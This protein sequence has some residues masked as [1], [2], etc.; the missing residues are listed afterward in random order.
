MRMRVHPAQPFGFEPCRPQCVEKPQRA[1][2]WIDETRTPTRPA[3]FRSRLGEACNCTEPRLGAQRI[4]RLSPFFGGV[5][6]WIAHDQTTAFVHSNQLGDVASNHLA[7]HAVAKQVAGAASRLLPI[8]LDEQAAFRGSECQQ[9]DANHPAACTEVS[10]DL[11]RAC[12]VCKLHEVHGVG[13]EAVAVLRLQ[14]RELKVRT[15][16]KLGRALGSVATRV[17]RRASSRGHAHARTHY[18]RAR[19]LRRVQGM[20]SE[21]SAASSQPRREPDPLQRRNTELVREFATALSFDVV[22]FASAQAPLEEEYA[23]YEAFLDSGFEGSMDWLREGREVRRR[24]DTSDM[25]AGAQSVVCLARNYHRDDDAKDTGLAPHIARYA[26]GR[27]YHNVVRRK[28]RQLAAFIRKLGAEA[29]PLIDD[30]PILEK[31]WAARAGL[32][33]VGKNGLLIVPGQGSYVLL[34]EVLTTLSLEPGSAIAQRCGSCTRCLDACPTD[35]FA[36]PF[37]LDPRRCISYWTIE[38]EGVVPPSIEERTGAWVFG[39][40]VCQ[41]VC[42]FN[43]GKHVGAST[44]TFRPHERWEQRSIA[45]LLDGAGDL[46][47]TPLARAGAEGLARNAAIALGNTGYVDGSAEHAALLRAAEHGPTPDVREHAA[48]ALLRGK[49]S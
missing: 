48:R 10:H 44:E 27:D 3:E 41:E 12:G 11:D 43:A 42:P 14:Q 38:N 30:A 29:R 13:I 36:A 1:A 33:F 5:I 49:R 40:D 21:D 6:G 19:P 37:V 28:L 18:T 47:G 17:E 4:A 26:R 22:G 20:R 46:S 32:G 34:G 23:R 39:C 2:G 25:L 45:A 7:A 15:R 8:D 9:R 31:A 24:L 35:A 16:T